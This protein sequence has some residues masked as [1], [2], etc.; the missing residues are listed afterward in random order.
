MENTNWENLNNMGN[1]NDT[2]RSFTANISNLVEEHIP[3]SR[4]N[5]NSINNKSYIDKP[6]I[7]AIKQKHKRWIKYTHCKTQ[8]NFNLY[9]DA[10]NKATEQVSQNT[11]L[12]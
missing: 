3:E 12:R 1:I 9:K 7:Q 5:P 6:T 10:R 2:W 8:E 4:V 11:T